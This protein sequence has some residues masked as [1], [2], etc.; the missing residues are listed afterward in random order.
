MVH[1]RVQASDV[2]DSG[3]EGNLNKYIALTKVSQLLSKNDKCSLDLV[4]DFNDMHNTQELV[5]S[6]IQIQIMDKAKKDSE[7]ANNL[8]EKFSYLESL[9]EKYKVNDISEMSKVEFDEEDKQKII[10]INSK[11]KDK[12]PKQDPIAAIDW[13]YS[14]I[15]EVLDA[16]PKNVSIY[17]VRGNNDHNYVQN[18]LTSVKFSDLET[19]IISDDGVNILGANNT[20]YAKEQAFPKELAFATDDSND[21]TKSEAYQKFNLKKTSGTKAKVI[22]LHGPPDGVNFRSGY[23]SGSVGITK[24]I[25]EHKPQLVECG[26]FHKA[27]I[28]TIN[29]VTYARTSPEHYFIHVFDESKSYK[30]SWVCKY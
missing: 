6:H 9:K 10:S 12:M 30:G 21:L 27:K 7:F 3:L 4:G 19:K 11:L 8:H 15:N 14:Q 28:K 23:D 16:V 18:I 5:N 25:E 20:N 22:Q 29:G 17:G 24:L 2:Q 13:Y 1:Y 26:H